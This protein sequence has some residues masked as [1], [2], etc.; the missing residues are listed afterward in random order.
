MA[1][2]RPRHRPRN[3]FV[4]GLACLAVLLPLLYL[5]FT[6]HV[7]FTPARS[8]GWSPRATPPRRAW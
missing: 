6:K 8:S 7:P 2:R 3:P 5:G 1:G 4:I